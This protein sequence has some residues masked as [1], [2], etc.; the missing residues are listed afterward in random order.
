M[1]LEPFS[2]A[3]VTPTYLGWLKDDETTRWLVK[4]GPDVGL[5][6]VEAF[7]RQ[8]IDSDD[9]CFFAIIDKVNGRH[10]GNVRIGPIDWEAG[11]S[12]F[13]VMIGEAGARGRGL[14]AEVMELVE[15]FCFGPLG[16]TQMRFPV[17]VANEQAMAMYRKRGFTLDGDWPENFE[18][19]GQS[20]PMAAVLKRRDA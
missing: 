6:E 16:L 10:V 7:C 17:V 12:R 15:N 8:M 18:K 2:G 20:W 1:V 9:D 3:F 5:D 4:A 11:T 19:G 14:G 13:G